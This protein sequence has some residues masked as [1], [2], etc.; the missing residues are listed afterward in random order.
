MYV[1]I[2]TY[3]CTTYIYVYIYNTKLDNDIIYIYTRYLVC[4]FELLKSKPENDG[5]QRRPL[6][7]TLARRWLHGSRDLT[8]A[9]RPRMWPCWKSSIRCWPTGASG[10]FGWMN[11]WMNW[12][13]LIINIFGISVFLGLVNI[14]LGWIL[15]MPYFWDFCFFGIGKFGEFLMFKGSQW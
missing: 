2:R 15:G 7:T 11:W 8:S 12:G 13:C 14:F 4:I 10:D 9:W 6:V 1:Y 5:G 3:Y